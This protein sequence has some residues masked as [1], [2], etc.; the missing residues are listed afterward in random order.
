M[1]V[2]NVLFSLSRRGEGRAGQCWTQWVKFSMSITR[3]STTS[4]Q[5]EGLVS[6]ALV[7]LCAHNPPRE[8]R[9]GRCD[10]LIKGCAAAQEKC[11]SI[12]YGNDNNNG[13]FLN[14][15]QVNML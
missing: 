13:T 11:M 8:S 3:T 9:T 2:T 1:H 5:I 10:V 14:S 4:W 7:G 12:I 15:N 6:L